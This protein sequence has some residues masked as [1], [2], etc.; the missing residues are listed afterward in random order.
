M[1]RL[2]LPK[3]ESRRFVLEEE[4]GKHETTCDGF[5]GSGAEYQAG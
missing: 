1:D 3:M 4:R 5:Q 2:H